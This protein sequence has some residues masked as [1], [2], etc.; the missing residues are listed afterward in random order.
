M[1]KIGFHLAGANP[2][3]LTAGLASGAGVLVTMDCGEAY[4]FVPGLKVI[5]WSLGQSCEVVRQFA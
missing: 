2:Q 5:D 4:L 1:R 3:K